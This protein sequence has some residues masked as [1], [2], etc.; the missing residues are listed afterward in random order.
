MN[1]V[2]DE[3]RTL[4][5]ALPLPASLSS[6][7][8]ALLHENAA[9]R[10]S[11][12]QALRETRKLVLPGVGECLLVAARPTDAQT[13]RLAALGFMLAGVCHEISNPLAAIHSMLQ[14]L[15]SKRGVS[16]AT[17]EKGLASIASNIDRVLA[18]TR[19]LGDFSR[20]GAE[21]PIAVALDAAMEAAGVLL[22][23]SEQGPQVRLDYRGAPGAA[24]LARSG[25]LEQVLFNILL[26]AAQAM[27]GSGRIE[28]R[29]E[30]AGESRVLVSIR[31]HG[32]GIRAEHLGRLFDP[33]FTTKAPGE[34][35]GLGL[36]IS[37][38][39]VHE[40]G[41]TI[42]ASNHAQGGACFELV[43]PLWRA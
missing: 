39:I 43:L 23:H 6:A 28:A 19:K 3:V 1:S 15:Q 24:I 34:G 41:G 4:L 30:V 27:Q 38:E 22:R 13:Q 21:P 10:E 16:P 37:Y 35:T 17:L 25:R 18:I 7:S 11:R 5:D 31:D 12:G 9:M 14:I 20:V 33:F 42:R 40:L 8:G 29:A 2:P 32:P 36:A 26:N